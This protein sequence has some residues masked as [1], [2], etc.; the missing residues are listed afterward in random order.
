MVKLLQQ[1]ATNNLKATY[2]E[3][4]IYDSAAESTYRGL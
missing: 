2:G 3:L 1:R 4:D